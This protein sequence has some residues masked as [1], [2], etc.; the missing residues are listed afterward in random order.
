MNWSLVTDNLDLCRAIAVRIPR[1]PTITIDDLVYGPGMDVLIRGAKAWNPNRGIKFTSYVFQGIHR[2]MFRYVQQAMR[3]VHVPIDDVD[4]PADFV[5]HEYR[6][7]AYN[8]LRGLDK[9]DR[10]VLLLRF[11]KGMTI[12]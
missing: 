7:D 11:W 8:V 6:I 10:F 2:S 3:R 12:R 5:E 4:E 1:S 9:L